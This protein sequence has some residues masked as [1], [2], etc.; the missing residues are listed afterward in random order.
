MVKYAIISDDSVGWFSYAV[1]FDKTCIENFQLNFSNDYL[2][3]LYDRPH[4]FASSNINIK[5]APIDSYY[6]IWISEYEFSRLKEMHN[7]YPSVL[8]F[9]KLGKIE[10]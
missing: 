2:R 10:V 9:E 4:S 7:L 5:G 3:N 8:R 6:G 1:K